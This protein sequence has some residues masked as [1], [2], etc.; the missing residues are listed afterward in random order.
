MLHPQMF[1]MFHRMPAFV[2]FSYKSN[3]AQETKK[4]LHFKTIYVSIEPRG[5]LKYLKSHGTHKQ[6]FDKTIWD[7]S[8][9]RTT[10]H[11]SVCLLSS[12]ESFRKIFS[13]IA[14]LICSTVSLQPKGHD[15]PV[16]C[17]RNFDCNMPV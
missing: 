13:N 1:T 7:A 11:K 16:R 10:Q 3:A 17:R 12:V 8:V 2:S 5:N 15:W 6:V 14:I 4:A 9:I